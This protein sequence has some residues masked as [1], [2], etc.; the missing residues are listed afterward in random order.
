MRKYA[1]VARNLAANF[2]EQA[3]FQMPEIARIPKVRID[4]DGSRHVLHDWS[5]W[6]PD[7]PTG[8][9]R[10]RAGRAVGGGMGRSQDVRGT[11][12]GLSADSPPTGRGL[13]RP[14]GEVR[15]EERIL[16]LSPSVNGQQPSRSN[17]R[18]SFDDLLEG[19]DGEVPGA[20]VVPTAPHA[21]PP[22][23]TQPATEGEL[24]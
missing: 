20:T 7:D 9:K 16:P 4:R 23:E 24:R 12:T 15:R 18:A 13:S 5:D 2:A 3:Q 17:G 1:A 19:D 22:A 10:K 11:V 6:Q 14:R 8:A 21:G